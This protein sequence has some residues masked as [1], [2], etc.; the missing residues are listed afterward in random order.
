LA[1]AGTTCGTLPSVGGGNAQPVVVLA[2]A[3]PCATAMR[4]GG[5]Y[6][7]DI[8]AGTAQ[9][10]G[11]FATEDSWQCDWPYVPGRSHANSYLQ[12]TD[13]AQNSFKIG[14]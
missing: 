1:P 6:L 14:Q 3:L 4:I 7:A 2:G 13:P 9:G 5:R 10:Q 12:C 8:R 11:Q